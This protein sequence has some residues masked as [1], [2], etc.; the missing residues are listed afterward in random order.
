MDGKVV[1]AGKA[2]MASIPNLDEALVRIED[3][4]RRLCQIEYY[5]Q[6]KELGGQG[7]RWHR[8][9]IAS[10]QL[11]SALLDQIN[12]DVM[13]LPWPKDTTIEWIR[14]AFLVGAHEYLVSS[15][16]LDVALSNL[17]T[18]EEWDGRAQPLFAW[19]E[20]RG[21]HLASW[22]IG[23]GEG[24]GREAESRNCP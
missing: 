6:M 10:M 4:E 22:G 23:G 21:L 8:P 18:L 24:G 17:D 13:S 9:I 5:N 2:A 11:S 16:S 20:E 12:N 1:A 7:P 19:D 3:L 14:Y 15:P